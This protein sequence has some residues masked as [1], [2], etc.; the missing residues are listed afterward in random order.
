MQMEVKAM[1]SKA[2]GSQPLYMRGLSGSSRGLSGSTLKLIACATMAVD[3][4]GAAVVWYILQNPAVRMNTER[5]ERIASL[6]DLMRA[7]GRI[8]FPIFC[9]LLVE[10]FF[11]TRSIKKYMERLFLFAL[12]SEFPFDFALKRDPIYPMKQNVYFTLLIGLITIWLIDRW[13]DMPPLQ[14]VSLCAGMMAARGL[15]TDYD[16][17]GVFLITVLYLFHDYRLI[18]CVTGALSIAWETTAPPA[19]LLCYLYNGK[20]GLKLKYFFYLFYP[21]HL[22]ILGIIRYAAVPGMF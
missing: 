13:R 14:A 8:A 9:F 21:V 22:V 6:Y 2:A 18:Q 17:K 19:F 16:Y 12:L 3:H 5:Y 4:T 10:G 7:I 20:R 11:H 1:E 15:M